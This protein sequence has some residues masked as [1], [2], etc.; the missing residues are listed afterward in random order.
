MTM[1]PP[2]GP[3]AGEEIPDG[4]EH[5]AVALVLAFSRTHFHA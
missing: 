3:D 4:P 5:A 2:A 1:V